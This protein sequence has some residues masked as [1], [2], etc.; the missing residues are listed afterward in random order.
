MSCRSCLVQFV[1]LRRLGALEGA[2]RQLWTV[3]HDLLHQRFVVERIF[4]SLFAEISLS[5]LLGNSLSSL[6]LLSQIGEG[7]LLILQRLRR[8]R[9]DRLVAVRVLGC[10][11][12]ATRHDVVLLGAL[13]LSVKFLDDLLALLHDAE[14]GLVH[15]V[16][17]EKLLGVDSLLREKTNLVEAVGRL[18]LQL[19]DY[20]LEFNDVAGRLLLLEL[21][22]E[23][24]KLFDPLHKTV[25]VSNH[26]VIS[27]TI[28]LKRRSS[29]EASKVLHLGL[30]ATKLMLHLIQLGSEML[31]LHKHGL[32]LFVDKADLLDE[33]L[34]RDPLVVNNLHLSEE[35]VCLEQLTLVLVDDALELLALTLHLNGV[36][37]VLLLQVEVLLQKLV[38]ASL[39]LTLSLAQLFDHATTSHVLVRQILE[40]LRKDA[41]VLLGARLKVRAS[42]HG[43]HSLHRN[44][45]ILLEV[46]SI[47][48]LGG[49][50]V[51][52]LLILP[53]QNQILL[54]KVRAVHLLDELLG[55][56]VLQ[57]HMIKRL[58][59]LVHFG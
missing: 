55:V 4:E 34:G 17:S 35:L 16:G 22:Y 56:E 31:V 24:L 33:V 38:P 54:G 40:Q 46:F 58:L 49:Q 44:L 12:R 13:D 9:P 14:V 47:L 48:L 39:A 2:G 28:S 30:E 26:R 59:H 1:E 42:R 8:E 29:P 43:S 18:N 41:G 23:V 3:T 7:A 52:K 27:N 45:D 10:S 53:F 36:R 50:I 15:F 20:L 6:V 21:N 51:Y 11:G 19:R 5:L 37:A 57:R 25:C 32:L